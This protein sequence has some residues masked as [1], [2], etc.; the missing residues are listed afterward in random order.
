MNLF[1]LLDQAATRF[2]E[3]GAVFRGTEPVHSF[4]ELRSRALRIA[5]GLRV[6]GQPGDRIAIATEN[7]PE[8]VEL[9]FAI[10]AMTQTYADFE[11]QIRLVLDVPAL[12]EAEFEEGVATVLRLVLGGLGLRT[13][14]LRKDAGTPL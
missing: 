13:A 5:A 12:G 2:P 3:R 10:W 14:C 1:S 11:T 6:S 9:F 8:Y 7:V 4:A